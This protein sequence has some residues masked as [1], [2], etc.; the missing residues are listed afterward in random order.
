MPALERALGELARSVIVGGLRRTRHPSGAV[1]TDLPGRERHDVG[2]PSPLVDS[3]GLEVHPEGGW[4]R[5][6]WRAPEEFETADGRVRST[7]T[8][9]YFLLHAGES[10]AWHRVRSDEMWLAH[11]GVVTVELG[12]D[13]AY[14]RPATRMVVGVDIRS[15][16][17]PQ[18]MVPAGTWQRTIP[19]EGDALVTCIVSP[20]FDFADFELYQATDAHPGG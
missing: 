17:A 1:L 9:I 14:P 12:G 18:V 4:F 15:G 10:S 6:T 11:L 19:G 3:L 7:A 8:L 13:G 2:M 5:Q 16:Q 20:G